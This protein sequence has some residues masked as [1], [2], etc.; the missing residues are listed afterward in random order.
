MRAMSGPITHVI[1]VLKPGG[2]ELQL[3][4]LAKA[5]AA[6]G[7]EVTVVCLSVGA[8]LRNELDSANVHVIALKDDRPV[9]FLKSVHVAARKAR[10]IHAWMY[11]GHLLGAMLR[12]FGDAVHIWGYRRTDPF[13]SGLKRRTR[14]LNRL[15]RLLAP[16]SADGLV[17]CAQAAMNRHVASGF[18]CSYMAVTLNSVP[19]KFFEVQ[20]RR[21]HEP[22]T[23][24]CLTRWTSDK[25]IDVLVRAWSRYV[26]LG[27]DGRL[28]LA[29][30]GIDSNNRALQRLVAQTGTA[31]TVELLGPFADPR[32]F[33][34]QLDVYVSPSRTEGFP[35]VVAEAMATGLPVVAT[36]AGGTA[37]VMGTTGVLVKSGDEAAIAEQL[38]QYAK[39]PIR[40][41][42]MGADARARCLETFTIE[43][44]E[45]VVRS[46]Y[47][48]ASKTRANRH[49]RKRGG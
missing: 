14:A 13:S 5:Q 37:E 4:W 12:P 25:G 48:A 46:T 31:D 22:F 42:T 44:N 26:A 23:V 40:R 17:F 27:G 32:E 35:N 29:G 10:V 18:R 45:S 49:Q 36:D 41:A 28:L 20:P 15:D 3:V 39:D 33:Y 21:R 47:V 16:I 6:L 24:G 11:H 1:P 7:E 2:A 8:N 43:A 19:P 30:P 9:A 38:I 34:R